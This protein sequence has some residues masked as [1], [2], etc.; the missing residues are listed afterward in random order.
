MTQKTFNI[1]MFH[2]QVGRTDGV[3]LEMDKWRCVL[4]SMGHTVHYAAGDL[5]SAEG[6]LIPEMYHHTPLAERL[7]ANT[8]IALTDYESDAD[9]RQA[10]YSLA[11][12]IEAKLRR[13]IAEK[14]IDFLLPQN[15]WSVAVNPSV[16]IAVTRV[17]RDLKLPTLAHNHDFYWERVDGV[18]LTCDSAVELADK[19]IPPHDPGIR[20]AV[21]NSLA[22]QE[23]AERKGIHARVVPN[24]FDFDAPPWQPDAYNADLRE[25]IGLRENDVMILQ[26]TRVVARKGIELAVDLVQA[27]NAPARRARLQR[28]GLYDGR[29]FDEDSRIVL[30]LAGY[31]RDDTSGSYVQRLREKIA[32][33]GID[34]LF[35]GD[36]IDHER[37]QEGARKIYSL[38][39]SYVFADFVT[40]PS[41]WEGWGNQLL[42]AVRAKLPIALFE[43]PV[44]VAD[45]KTRGFQAVSFGSTIHSRDARG[46]IRVAP[47]IIEAAAD[48]TVTLL[49]DATRRREMVEHNFQVAKR[50][51]SLDALRD[52]L[53]A[54]MP[55]P[56]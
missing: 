6:T 55:A 40:Y 49:T 22:Q 25:R 46:L 17:M 52:H 29:P 18:C 37:R 5:G 11:D 4:E 50:Y 56:S 32:D 45:I 48:E 43:Y 44:Y 31:T 12:V 33:A 16:S 28:T 35:I 26:A 51:F 38:W 36:L 20:H 3:S 23:L 41:W 9:Y 24:V 19:Y 54:L 27:L 15:V 13:W 42:E 53:E 21:I 14:G 10:L 34:A 39:D 30:V 7:Y 8:F 47:E 2:Y 1:G